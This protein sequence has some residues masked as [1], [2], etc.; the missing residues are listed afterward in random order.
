MDSDYVPCGKAEAEKG[1]AP[2]SFKEFLQQTKVAALLP[3]HEVF[4]VNADAPVQKAFEVLREHN[5]LS[6]PV[7][8]KR[9]G[10][11]LAFL[12]IL[13]IVHCCFSDELAL[14]D[15]CSKIAGLS[16]RNKFISVDESMP[17]ANCIKRLAESRARR[18]AVSS[19]TDVSSVVTESK[20]LN[21]I[22]GPVS[23]MSVASKTL[24]ELNLGV[25]D[26]LVVSE[27]E[28][29][30]SAFLT[31]LTKNVG[32][33]AVVDDKGNLVGNLSASDLKGC[34]A[35]KE[36][37]VQKLDCSVKS[38]ISSERDYP[39]PGPICS[40]LK[41]TVEEVITKIIEA[42]VHRLYVVTENGGLSGVVSIHDI[43]KLVVSHEL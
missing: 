11:Y 18:L 17:L 3:N 42:K 30:K 25:K 26:V 4:E 22:G 5:I 40:T 43:I 32:A 13:D 37:V 15:P 41:A 21:F 36:E 19:G 39:N 35:T 33:V 34:G 23:S 20:I 29:A 8:D 2:K 14:S 28:S 7:L 27:S 12:D 6:V 16:E 10:R 1:A 24:E 31:L 9:S 38:F